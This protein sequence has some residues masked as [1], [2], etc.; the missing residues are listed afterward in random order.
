MNPSSG[1]TAGIHKCELK[2]VN[3]SIAITVPNTIHMQN[4]KHSGF[5]LDR[6][7]KF[8]M[9]VQPGV[10]EDRDSDGLIAKFD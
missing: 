2:S 10:Y 1:S 4:E 6:L 7:S 8:V 3:S 5:E 9:G